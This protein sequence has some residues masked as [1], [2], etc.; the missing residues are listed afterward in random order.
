METV[1]SS[2]FTSKNLLLYQISNFFLLYDT[3]K[4][5]TNLLRRHEFLIGYEHIFEWD[6]S[7]PILVDANSAKHKIFDRLKSGFAYSNRIRHISNDVCNF[8]I[9][10]NYDVT[11]RKE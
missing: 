3:S 6:S 7:M 2:E 4:Q 11:K 5:Y 1:L 8:T 9:G 10:I